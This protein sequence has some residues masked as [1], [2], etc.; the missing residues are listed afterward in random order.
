M[1]LNDGNMKSNKIYYHLEKKIENNKEKGTSK[2]KQYNII[3]S[4]E[5]TPERDKFISNNK[6]LK[7][8]NKFDYI[9]SIG[10]TLN[11]TQILKFGKDALVQQIE[12]DQQLFLSLLEINSILEL[13]RVKSSQ[14]PYTGKNITVGII[15]DGVNYKFPSVSNVTRY[16]INKVNLK[17]MK[18]HQ[19]THGTVIASIIGN[20]FKDVNDKVVGIAPDVNLLDFDASDSTHEYYFSNVL[21]IF[22]L[23]RQKNIQVDVLLMS[24]STKQSSDGLDIL[25]LACDMI[26]KKGITIVCPAGNLGPAA[27]TIGSPSAAKTVF[28]FG[29]LKKDLVLAN[30]SGRGPTFDERIKP[31]FCLPSVKIEV[32]LQADFQVKTTGSSV[33]AAIG[34]GMIAIIK[35]F[36]PKITNQEIYELLKTSCRDLDEDPYS[37]GN[38]MP[39]LVSVFEK[40]GAIQ[41]EILP[42][43]YLIKKSLKI[44]IEFIV[45][46]IVL[47][48]FFYFF[49]I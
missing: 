39:N 46:F 11:K 47:F 12:E 31:D 25:S 6:E 15:D 18:E 27:Y 21:K 7:I 32:P 10:V 28:T 8:L 34:A 44:S 9:P 42:Y 20:Q 13:N 3:I 4:F 5:K 43:N 1:L 33:A 37:Q 38:G 41:E 16:S 35:Q 19:I 36:K 48:Y 2:G 22:D 29:S 24:L 17:K 45:V 23:I 49:R 14:F 40:L 30:F 26:S